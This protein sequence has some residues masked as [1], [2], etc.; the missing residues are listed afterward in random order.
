MRDKTKGLTFGR[1]VHLPLVPG[2]TG[3][4]FGHLPFFFGLFYRVGCILCP[5]I[6][7]N[8]VG[9]KCGLICPGAN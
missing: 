1:E 8:S 4:G 3:S 6:V 5:T 7:A 9:F 2:G